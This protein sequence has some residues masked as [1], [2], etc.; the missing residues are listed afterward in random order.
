MMS[1]DHEVV[2][3]DGGDHQLHG[4][5]GAVGFCGQSPDGSPYSTKP[6]MGMDHVKPDTAVGYD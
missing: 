5:A 2:E 1:R 6:G 4:R 3:L